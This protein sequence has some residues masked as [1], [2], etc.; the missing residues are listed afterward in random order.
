MSN[1]VNN[2]NNNKDNEDEVRVNWNGYDNIANKLCARVIPN[3]N[4]TI[5]WNSGMCKEWGNVSSDSHYP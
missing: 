3:K 4:I 1:Y 2:N 5:K